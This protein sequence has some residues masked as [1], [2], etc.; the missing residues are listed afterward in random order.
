MYLQCKGRAERGQR[1]E[2]QHSGTHKKA[3]SFVAVGIR[4]GVQGR[5][6][7]LKMETVFVNCIGTG[8]LGREIC[9]ER[10]IGA[11]KGAFACDICNHRG[12]GT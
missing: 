8:I 2:R 6:Y 10:M 4:E 3:S 12:L 11:R 7:L 9:E 1:E 5:K